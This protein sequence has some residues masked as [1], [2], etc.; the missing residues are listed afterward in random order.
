LR[1][2]Q[3]EPFNF[4]I[5]LVADGNIQI[6]QGQLRYHP[7]VN[8]QETYPIEVRVAQSCSYTTTYLTGSVAKGVVDDTDDETSGGRSLDQ[9]IFTVYWNGRLISE[10]T[11]KE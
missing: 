2:A 7:F 6:V 5:E 4:E 3:G 9:P 11:V 8:D 10:S 1:T